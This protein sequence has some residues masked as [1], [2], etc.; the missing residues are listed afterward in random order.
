MFCTTTRCKA[1]R[2]EDTA[3]SKPEGPDFLCE[4]AHLLEEG[5]GTQVAIPKPQYIFPAYEPHQLL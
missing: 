2:R 4:E 5:C 3:D 1:S